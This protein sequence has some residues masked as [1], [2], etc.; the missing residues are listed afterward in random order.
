MKLL[1]LKFGQFLLGLSVI[2]GIIL[3]GVQAFPTILWGIKASSISIVGSGVVV[4]LTTTGFVIAGAFFLYLLI[5]IRDK[6]IENN[7]LLKKEGK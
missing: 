1:V 7:E 3:A 6:L 4:F 5:D 2:G